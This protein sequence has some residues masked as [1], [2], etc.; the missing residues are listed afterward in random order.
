MRFCFQYSGL[1]TGNKEK[2][3]LLWLEFVNVMMKS[4]LLFLGLICLFLACNGEDSKT[5]TESPKTV[6]RYNQI[7]SV[8]SLDPAFAKSQNNIWAVDHLYNG[9]VQLDEQLNIRPAIAASWKISE[10]GLTYIFRLRDDVFFHDNKVFENG[11]G[12]KV[13][14]EDVVYSFERIISDEV[15]SPGSWIFKGNVAEKEP[16][17]A[18]DT[19]TFQLRLQKAFRHVL[20]I[21]TMQ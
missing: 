21:L 12:R 7:N 15:A 1:S 10:D 3:L 19:H 13:T 14:A 5:G 20:G 17:K 8:T 18:L 16:F 9:L 2:K 11:K 6:F 4:K